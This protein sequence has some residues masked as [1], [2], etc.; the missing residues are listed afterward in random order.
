MGMNLRV[1]KAP[2][3]VSAADA[4]M[5]MPNPSMKALLAAVVSVSPASVPRSAAADVAAPIEFLAA[6]ARS[7]V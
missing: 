6:A 7:P 4:S 2:P 5:V 3:N 1:N